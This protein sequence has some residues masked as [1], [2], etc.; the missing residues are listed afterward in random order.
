MPRNRIVVFASMAVAVA[1]ASFLIP[2]ALSL[3][4]PGS[5]ARLAAPG[6]ATAAAPTEYQQA[7]AALDAKI[8]AAA[9]HAARYPRDWS[10]LETLASLQRTRG[11]LTG[12]FE[13]YAQAQATL[14]RAFKVAPDGAG[15]LLERAQLSYTLHRLPAV[16]R[17]L[18][19]AERS[20]LLQAGERS[21]ITALTA[22][23][24]FHT[25]HYADALAGFHKLEQQDRH[26]GSSFRLALYAW[27][28]G[29][30]AEAERRLDEGA[31]L[32]GSPRGRPRA[33]FELQRGLT[34]LDRGQLDLALAHYY[35]AEQMFGGWW[36]VDEHIAEALA[37]KGDTVE[38]ERRY[39][40]LVARTGNP[41]FMDALA[42][43][44]VDRAPEEAA[45][46]VARATAHYDHWL[47]VLPEAS[48]GHA[49]H[50]FLKH[51][52][53]AQALTLAQANFE[54]RPGG[55][56]EVLLAQ[57]LLR[58][59]RCDEARAHTDAVL[60]TPY[61]TADTHATAAAA[62]ARCGDPQRA[63]TQRGLANAMRPDAMAEVAYLTP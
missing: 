5:P 58:A 7:L 6:P 16:A 21:A 8:E 11:T 63:A 43:L 54:L 9:H 34:H 42:D 53:S 41:E 37:R 32:V 36:L 49:L 30:F 62:Q 14:D 26:A 28:T 55:E 51:G 33:W 12:D 61:R 60:A 22:D 48:Y 35:K 18:A 29:D 52:T 3:R 44:I 13:D 56:A 31:D 40:D 20:A 17:D 46:L 23:L 47:T 45:A 50:H 4:D 10:H 24:A 1:G 57:A 2:A 59:G 27:K 25:G 15:P 38:A 19:T 39:R